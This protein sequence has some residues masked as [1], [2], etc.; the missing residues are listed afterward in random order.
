MKEKAGFGRTEW[1][2]LALFVI[3]AVATAFIASAK[4]S[5]HT[6]SEQSYTVTVQREAE[7]PL[8]ENVMVDINSADVETLATLDGVGEVLAQR[9]IDY[10]EENGEFENVEEL[11]EVKGVGDAIL[12]ANR[13]RLCVGG[14]TA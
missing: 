10:R 7:T 13:E 4:M 6:P 12:A 11:R 1:L 3:F 9:I 5:A 8:P 14:G 2:L